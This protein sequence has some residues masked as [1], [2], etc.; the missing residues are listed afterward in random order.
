MRSSRRVALL[1]DITDHRPEILDRLTAAGFELLDCHDISGTE[2]QAALIQSLKGA[3]GVVA[4][5]EHFS[6]D[7]LESLPSLR[8][9]A[10]PGVGTGPGASLGADQGRCRQNRPLQVIVKLY[11]VDRLPVVS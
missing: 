9:I 1:S 5:G 8:V 2:D 7:V 11:G 6:R 10:R 4:G 3:W